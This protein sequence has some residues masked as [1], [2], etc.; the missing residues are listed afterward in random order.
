M[1]HLSLQCR[2]QTH[3]PATSGFIGPKVNHCSVFYTFRE[4]QSSWTPDVAAGTAH[5]FNHENKNSDET[6]ESAMQFLLRSE[7]DAASLQEVSFLM[8]WNGRKNR[9][10]L[11]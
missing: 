3:L 10:T 6:Y 7:M 11:L 1:Q 9:G 4:S 2:T 5:H 8:Q